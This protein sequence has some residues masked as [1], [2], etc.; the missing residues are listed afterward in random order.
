MDKYMSLKAT[1]IGCSIADI[2]ARLTEK[3]SFEDI[4]RVCEGLQQYKVTAARLP[5]DLM[6]K[7][8][9]IKV[10]ESVEP[11]RPVDKIHDDSVDDSLL[12]MAGML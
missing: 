1:T 6:G 7:A 3:Y 5:I 12:R 4:D 10:T 8:Q 9:S 2:K 11:I